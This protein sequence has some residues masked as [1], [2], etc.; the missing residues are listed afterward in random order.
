MYT[1]VHST[2][3]FACVSWA[4]SFNARYSFSLFLILL[5]RLYN[6]RS[7]DCI[8]SDLCP[9]CCDHVPSG[10]PSSRL[11]ERGEHGQPH[12][13]RHEGEGGHRHLSRSREGHH[14]HKLL[15]VA[16]DIMPHAACCM[17]YKA[18]I[19]K[20]TLGLFSFNNIL[21]MFSWRTALTSTLFENN[22]F[23]KCKDIFQLKDFFLIFPR[24]I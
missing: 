3:L 18:R 20:R 11:A 17:S 2:A 9:W 1:Y 14:H 24:C 22:I 6:R 13:L 21:K 4:G 8:L 16:L 10:L 15:C 19:L 12:H 23:Q 5:G 7:T